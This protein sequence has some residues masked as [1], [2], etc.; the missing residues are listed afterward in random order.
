MPHS[1][2]SFRFIFQKFNM[3]QL[4]V[5]TLFL[6]IIASKYTRSELYTALADLEELLQTESVLINNLQSY[7]TAQEQKLELLRR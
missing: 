6:I 1:L 4:N 7:I 3:N 5:F 2:I